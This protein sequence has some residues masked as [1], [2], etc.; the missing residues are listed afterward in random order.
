MFSLSLDVPA[1][2][3]LRKSGDQRQIC[4]ASL[5]KK[6]KGPAERKAAQMARKLKAKP[7]ISKSGQKASSVGSVAKKVAAAK[8]GAAAAAKKAVA[9]KK[10]AGAAKKAAKAASGKTVVAFTAKKAHGAKKAQIKK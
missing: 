8:K 10:A 1:Q 9:A 5:A 2:T 6:M 4:S 3:A 7:V